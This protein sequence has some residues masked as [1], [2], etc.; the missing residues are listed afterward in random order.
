MDLKKL[1]KKS[2]IF[3]GI[4]ITL[5]TIGG[6][7]AYYYTGTIIPNQFRAHTYGVT[8]E[9]EFYDTWGTKKVS[10][11]NQEETNAPVFLRI[12]YNEAWTKEINN[13]IFSLDNNVGGVNVVTKTWTTDFTNNFVDG[14]DGW[15]YY[16]KIL[17]AEE[18]VQVLDAIALNN[19]LIETSPYYED[20]Q[21]YDYQ[22]IFNFEAIQATSDAAS[23]IWEKTVTI[24]GDDVA[25]QL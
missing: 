24:T 2:L 13:T 3:L 10:F 21:T 22:L 7:L 25:W 16:K 4:A 6:T 5:A 23:E 19:T 11:V 1:K 20:Y 17:D 15:Y 12:N 9:E 14:N 8:I 18:S